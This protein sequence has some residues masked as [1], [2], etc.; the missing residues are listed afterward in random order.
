MCDFPVNGKMV[1]PDDPRKLQ[2]R[3]KNET[4]VMDPY[5]VRFNWF[6]SRAGI[7]VQLNLLARLNEQEA[8]S[9]PGQYPPFRYHPPPPPS[10]PARRYQCI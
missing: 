10:P 7:Q 9:K 6:L 4:N 8:M 3:L 1:D 2:R 5:V